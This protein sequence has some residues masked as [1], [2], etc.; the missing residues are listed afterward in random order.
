MHVDPIQAVIMVASAVA[1]VAVFLQRRGV[2]PR[3]LQPESR[4][5]VR[6]SDSE[7]ACDR[8]DG[9]TERVGWTDLQ[10]VEVLTTSDGPWSPDVFWVL[11]GTAGGCVIPHGATGDR[12]LL[13]RLQT[14]PDFDNATLIRAMGSATEKRFLCWQRD[15]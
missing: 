15:P 5:I 1:G 13:E 9:K 2:A 8:P 3:S 14:L 6:L 12:E 7:I 10:R 4:F 11:H